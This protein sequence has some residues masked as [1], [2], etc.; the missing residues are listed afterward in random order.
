M[1]GL[2][3]LGK[4]IPSANAGYM[5]LAGAEKDGGCKKV[6]V[7]GGVS[8]KKGCCNFFQPESVKADQFRCGE[9]EYVRDR[10]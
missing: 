10:G 3:G 7:A 2:E 1:K 4:K 6:E 9:C 5:E 8:Q